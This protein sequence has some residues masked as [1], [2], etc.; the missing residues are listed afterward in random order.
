MRHLLP[1]RG[2]AIGVLALS[3]VWIGC[4]ALLPRPTP[5]STFYVMSSLATRDPNAAER[6]NATRPIIG[7]GPVQLPPHLNRPQIVSSGEGNRLVLSDFHR[8][9]EPLN[10]SVQQAVG[11]NLAVLM[12]TKGVVF[13]PWRLSDSVDYQVV[14]RITRFAAQP[15]GSVLLT[16]R[17]VLNDGRSR[18]LATRI[19]GLTKQATV[20]D[21]PSIVGAMSDA[22]I[23]L[24]REIAAEIQ[25]QR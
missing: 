1:V 17:W 11:E 21:Y 4:G 15:D 25:A 7:V 10:S 13:F 22:L 23:D 8:W 5:P 16:C 12:S 14:L 9:A 3:L 18:T 2:L 19:S 6:I 24:S 20:G